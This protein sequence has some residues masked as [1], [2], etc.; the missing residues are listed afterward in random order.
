MQLWVHRHQHSQLLQV[1]PHML[2][3]AVKA[4]STA[5]QH[6]QGGASKASAGSKG[7][8]SKRKAEAQGGERS[9]GVKGGGGGGKRRVERS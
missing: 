1:W 5:L 6:T 9:M 4:P 8:G 2:A 3:E 7:K